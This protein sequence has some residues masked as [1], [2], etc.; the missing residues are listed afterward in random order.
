MDNQSNK[1]TVDFASNPELAEVFVDKKP[2]HKC[3]LTIEFSIDEID[4]ESAVGSITSITGYGKSKGEIK[5]DYQSPVM[6]MM[7]SKGDDSDKESEPAYA[8]PSL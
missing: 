8:G 7:S 4:D 3:K 2:G 5:P 1:I 6:I